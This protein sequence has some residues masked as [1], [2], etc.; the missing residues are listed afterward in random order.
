MIRV[1]SLNSGEFFNVN[2]ESKRQALCYAFLA[3]CQGIELEECQ[4]PADMVLRN[5][6]ERAS[7]VANGIITGK[8]SL[9]LGNFAVWG[10]SLQLT[11]IG[12]RVGLYY[13]DDDGNNY[14]TVVSTTSLE[15]ERCH[16]RLKRG[17]MQGK[18][19]KFWCMYCVEVTP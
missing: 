13:H 19:E 1:F 9:G 5:F 6:S 16:R 8:V 2:A 12:G 14:G 4:K 15:C 10:N 17:Y 7:Q 11:R 3:D 18:T